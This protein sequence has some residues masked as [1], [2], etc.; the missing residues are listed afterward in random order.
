MMGGFGAA[1][2]DSTCWKDMCGLARGGPDAGWR[3]TSQTACD[4]GSIEPL[5]PRT[6][7]RACRIEVGGDEKET[8]ACARYGRA[9]S[10]WAARKRPK[11]QQAVTG[12]REE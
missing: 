6:V 1:T 10:R 7:S 11:E 4:G 8:V 2:F 3:G 9:E 5:S 12:D